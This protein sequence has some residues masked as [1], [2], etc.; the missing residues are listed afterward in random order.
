MP[1]RA[2]WRVKVRFAPIGPNAALISTVS[3]QVI[4]LADGVRVS[5]GATPVGSITPLVSRTG[6]R[7]VPLKRSRSTRPVIPGTIP[8]ELYC[9]N[10]Q[11]VP[12]QLPPGV[13]GPGPPTQCAT[14]SDR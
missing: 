11:P 13:D 14:Q 6:V 8:L 7:S 2:P 12:P 10:V 1:S 5:V 4:T 3:P 9:Q